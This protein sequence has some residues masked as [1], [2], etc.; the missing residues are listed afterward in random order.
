M[1]QELHDI[2]VTVS[3]DYWDLLK[4]YI[5]SQI[6]DLQNSPLETNNSYNM[7]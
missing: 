7:Y 1:V 6:R 5:H 3:W 4:S 2:H